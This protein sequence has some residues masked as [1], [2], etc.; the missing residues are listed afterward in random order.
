MQS[1]K[2]IAGEVH[3]TKFGSFRHD[4]IIGKAFGSKVCMR[5]YLLVDRCWVAYFYELYINIYIYRTFDT[6]NEM[7]THQTH[8]AGAPTFFHLFYLI[9]IHLIHSIKVFSMHY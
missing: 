2:I 5:D 1:V 4:D 8:N 3:Q 7:H 9:C 6:M